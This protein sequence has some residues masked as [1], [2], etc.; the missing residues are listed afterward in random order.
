MNKHAQALGR[1]GGRAKSDAKARAAKENGR[2]GGWLEI[3]FVCPQC[4]G[5]HFGR[6]TEAI[7]LGQGVRILRTVRCHT[8]R[9]GWR[10]EWPPRKKTVG[11][12]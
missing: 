4:G 2:K 6:D 1:F 7:D 5:Q 3:P 11:P 12:V 10:G 9:C 8:N